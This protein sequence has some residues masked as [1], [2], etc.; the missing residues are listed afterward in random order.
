MLHYVYILKGLGEVS[1]LDTNAAGSCSAGSL[2]FVCSSSSK[3]EPTCWPDFNWVAG[4]C[5]LFASLFSARCPNSQAPLPASELFCAASRSAS[6]WQFTRLCLGPDC[7]CFCAH[8][9]GS[10]KTGSSLRAMR[11]LCLWFIF[12]EA[13]FGFLIGES[14]SAPLSSG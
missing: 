1:F 5:C 10:L 9:T 11:S 12:F 3:L 8:S 13:S 6:C 2:F 4:F 14:W 7:W